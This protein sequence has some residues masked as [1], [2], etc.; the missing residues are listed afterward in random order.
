MAVMTE[1]GRAKRNRSRVQMEAES[2]LT[3]L[4]KQ[5]GDA[6][7]AVSFNLEHKH[8]YDHTILRDLTLQKIKHL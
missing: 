7:S 8:N 2:Q 1:I 5:H 6:T 3:I 4:V